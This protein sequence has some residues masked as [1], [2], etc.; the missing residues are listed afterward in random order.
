[1]PGRE[2]DLRA[3]IRPAPMLEKVLVRLSAEL[4]NVLVLECQ[5]TGED[6]AEAARRH[7]RASLTGDVTTR[8]L[9]QIEDR[10]ERIQEGQDS[11]LKST[12]P[13]SIGALHSR[14]AELSA[15]SSRAEDQIAGLGTLFRQG[16]EKI[17]AAFLKLQDFVARGDQSK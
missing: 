6:L 8:R 1:V 10:L 2:D 5:R 15:S 13:E 16:F 4:H 11:F 3:A 17:A 7:I 9:D 14:L 12:F